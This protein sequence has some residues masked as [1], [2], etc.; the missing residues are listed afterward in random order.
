MLLKWLHETI[1]KV[2]TSNMCNIHVF[3][4]ELSFG[5]W[6]SMM[7]V[8]TCPCCYIA[9]ASRACIMTSACKD[10]FYFV[11]CYFWSVCSIFTCWFAF[12]CVSPS[13]DYLT[14]STCQPV[15]LNPTLPSVFE[16]SVFRFSSVLCLF[17]SHVWFNFSFLPEPCQLCL[18]DFNL[19]VFSHFWPL[20]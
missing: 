13:C 9:C 10:L 2:T 5:H 16:T 8:S 14:C 18:P 4:H 11:F 1:N 17:A 3:Y 12:L 19:V 20:A 6:N 15:Y 7:A